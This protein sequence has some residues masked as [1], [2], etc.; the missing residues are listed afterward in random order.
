MSWGG[1]WLD[2]GASLRVARMLV[3]RGL[4]EGS[5]PSYSSIIAGKYKSIDINVY[6]IGVPIIS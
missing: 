2:Q 3:K 6:I 4:S 1:R 5:I